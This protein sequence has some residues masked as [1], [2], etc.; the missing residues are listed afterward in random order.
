MKSVYALLQG[1]SAHA[2]EF[3][4]NEHIAVLKELLK[5][6][7]ANQFERQTEEENDKHA[8]NMAQQAR[9]NQVKSYQALVAKNEEIEAAKSQ[10]KSAHEA[11]KAQTE[12]DPT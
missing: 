6:Y 12:A 3:Q 10:E 11:D 7:K 1:P 9:A 4:S 5:T 2:T 8:F